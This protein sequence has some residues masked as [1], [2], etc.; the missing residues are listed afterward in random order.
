MNR[1]LKILVTGADGF[2]GKRL[3]RKLVLDGQSV[4]THCLDDGD[5]TDIHF[6]DI[7]ADWVIH[8]AA[9]TFVPQSWKEPYDYY[10]VNVLGTANVLEYCRKNGAGITFLSTYIYGLPE[11]TPVLESHR[12]APNT[13]Y[14]HSKVLAESLIQFY[15]REFQVNSVTL[16]PFNIYGAGQDPHFLIP[17]IIN[18]MLDS[19]VKE[20][21]VQDLSPKRDY[22]FVEDLIDAIILTIAR[23]GNSIYNI[24]SGASHSV[25]EVL[26][27][28]LQ[29]ANM[30]K[31]YREIGQ[32]R[33]GELDDLCADISLVRQDLGWEPK[34][35][36]FDGLS[37]MIVELKP[38]WKEL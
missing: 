7:E 18:Q 25:E 13:P 16:R 22:L 11:A 23:Q 3:V 38:E 14:N 9:R 21:T 20:I 32:R 6:D 1:K 12:F 26:L 37:K 17:F 35:S 27:L 8:L 31:P 19:S 33:Q 4:I 5:I 10:R 24:G 28:A 29:A 30:T 15:S 36:L 34:V 2:I